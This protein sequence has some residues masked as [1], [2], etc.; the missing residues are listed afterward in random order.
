MVQSPNKAEFAPAQSAEVSLPEAYRSSTPRNQDFARA[1]CAANAELAELDSHYAFVQGHRKLDQSQQEHPADKA[2]REQADARH[3][4]QRHLDDGSILLTLTDPNAPDSAVCENVARRGI[5]ALEGLV[6]KKQDEELPYVE[7]ARKVSHDITRLE[8]LQAFKIA[9]EHPDQV[10]EDQRRRLSI[11]VVS[12]E[13]ARAR[14]LVRKWEASPEHQL[15]VDAYNAYVV[16]EPEDGKL[17]LALRVLHREADRL[18]SQMLIGNDLVR[19]EKANV[20]GLIAMLDARANGRKGKL[21]DVEKGQVGAELALIQS[22]AKGRF[23]KRE[24]VEPDKL[25]KELAEHRLSRLGDIM[26]DV[27]LAPAPRERKEALQVVDNLL[28]SGPITE[29]KRIG[30]ELAQAQ[31]ATQEVADAAQNLKDLLDRNY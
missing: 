16:F 21:T 18:N 30:A 27:S 14:E 25:K 12:G 19:A 10:S 23:S 31:K 20:D 13:I 5:A 26:R 2:R 6:R 22:N 24:G 17:G 7:A 9:V 8:N 4:F 28:A 1:V 15:S 3:V 11:D 29:A